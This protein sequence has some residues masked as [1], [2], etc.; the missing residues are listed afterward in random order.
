MF[1]LSYVYFSMSTIKN[2][3]FL[4]YTPISCTNYRLERIMHLC[5]QSLAHCIE[6]YLS[7]RAC[8][9]GQESTSSPS[10]HWVITGLDICKRRS[11]P[12]RKHHWQKSCTSSSF[13]ERPLDINKDRSNPSLPKLLLLGRTYHQR[14]HS[15]ILKAL[16][17]GWQKYLNNF[18][19]ISV[20]YQS[21]KCTY[22]A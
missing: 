16:Q 20:L 11:L 19:K 6:E 17:R 18:L 14:Y 21:V 2:E 5:F 22:F 12:Y 10:G 7:S 1:L 13:G 9:I 3:C 15:Q 4:L 8:C